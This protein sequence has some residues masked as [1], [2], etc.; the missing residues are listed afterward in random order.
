MIGAIRRLESRFSVSKA[1]LTVG[2][3]T[4][5]TK[6]VALV[7]DALLAS[8]IGPGPELD[9]YYAAFRLP[10]FIFNIFVLGTLSVAFIP[11]FTQQL[12]KDRAQAERLAA[13]VLSIAGGAM[14]LVCAVLFLAVE[15]LTKAIAPGFDG[16]QFDL[17]VR[18][19]KVFLLSP[20]LFTVSSVY[21]AVLNSHKRFFVVSLAP[22]LYNVGI[23]LGVVFGYAQF[24]ILGVGGGVILGALLYLTVLIPEAARTGFAYRPTLDLKDPA[25]LRIGRLFWPRLFALDSSQVSLLIATVVGSSLS[26]GTIS[27]YNFANNLQAVPL[28]LF[29][30]SFAVA[31]FPALS[32]ARA[33]GDDR[34][35]LLLLSKTLGQILFFIIPSAVLLLVLRAYA[36]RIPLGYGKFGWDDT[37]STFTTLGVFAFGLLGQAVVPTL[38]RAFYARHD[39]KTPV[40]ASVSATAINAAAA[41]WFGHRYGSAGLAAAFVLANALNAVLLF[42][43]LRGRLIGEGL[44]HETRE[45]LDRPLI[46]GAVKI[47]TASAALGLATYAAVY[48]AEPFVN[49]RTVLGIAAQ[50][51]AA[52][53]LGVL[54]FTYVAKRLG[55]PQV[56]VTVEY[57]RKVWY[58]VKHLW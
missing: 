23:I 8:R 20:V 7:R 41:Y 15:P 17:T 2:V 11:V 31:A 51:A 35:F 43:L 56:T 28:G 5:L 37:I 38:S 27:V 29:A 16:A 42:V 19:T 12:T 30:F 18:L 47:L 57:L 34:G 55:I 53:T 14:L 4:L 26:E 13:S 6:L 45:V 24:G 10:D 21:S 3:M 44:H 50:A 33:K 54:V 36:V 39:T 32:E 9:A 49:T 48:L 52:A 40:L 1:A 25:L 46:S 22:L 58:T